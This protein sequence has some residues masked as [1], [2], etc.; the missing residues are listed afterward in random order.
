MGVGGPTK[1]GAGALGGGATRAPPG[2]PPTAPPFVISL[3]A[4]PCRLEGPEGALSPV[5]PE[6]P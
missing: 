1:P 3:C 6:G 2:F 5:P 4:P